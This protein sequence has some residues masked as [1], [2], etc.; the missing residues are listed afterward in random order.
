[1]EF[2]KQT[3]SLGIPL[4]VVSGSDE[5]E[6]IDVFH[7]RGILKLFKHIYGSPVNK[8]DNTF[9]VV[10]SIGAQKKG[11]FFGDSKSDYSAASKYGLDFVF[12]SGLSEWE[13]NNKSNHSNE[14]IKNFLEI[15]TT[16]Q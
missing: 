15:C 3:N 10:Q 5:N 16:M 8:N 7:Q 2:L 1:M 6:L 13:E 4:F 12:V 14:T 9:K 11:C